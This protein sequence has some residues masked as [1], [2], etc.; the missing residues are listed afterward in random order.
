[1]I[2]KAMNLLILRY[3]GNKMKFIENYE[4][5]NQQNKDQFSRVSNKLLSIGFLT[6]KKEDNKKDYYFIQSHK[7][8]FRDYF[9][10]INWELEID[11][12]FGVVHLNNINDTNRKNFKLNES[13]ILLILRLL[14]QEK[15]QEL[16]LANNV[17]IQIDEIHTRYDA[18]KIRD[19]RLDKTTLR[20]ALRMFKSYNIVDPLDSDY[21]LGDSRM[22][23]YP[24]ILLAIKVDDINRV[25]EKLD[26][27]RRGGEQNE[28]TDED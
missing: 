23:I 8:L 15:L 4:K 16:S 11:E 19:K 9:S 20:S 10:Y 3:G 28:E 18:L 12:G 25:Y 26:S 6:K 17:T 14:F 2:I 5:L 13:I 1:M 27:Y 21:A 22:I 24:T 7:E